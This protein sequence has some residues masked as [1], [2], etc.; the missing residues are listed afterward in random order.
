MI[1]PPRGAERM[2]DREA[3][4][5][6]L[7][8]RVDV[9]VYALGDL[10]EPYWSASAWWRRGDALLGIV[11]LPD[12]EGV[13][14]YGVSTRAPAATCALIAEAAVHLPVGQLITGPVGLGAAL[15]D[16]RP[17]RWAR[18]HQ[19]YV[20][21]DPSALI[22]VDSSAEALGPGD[23]DELAA[24]YATEPGA[25]FFLA[26]MLDG[27]VFFGIRDRGELVSVAGTHVVSI[28]HDV[29]A[30]GGVF[31]VPE[32]RE[33]G[34]ARL[35]T[36]AVASTLTTRVATIGLNVMSSNVVARNI[37]ESLGFTAV[38]AYEEAELG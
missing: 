35:L 24:V 11:Q 8:D 19:R 25:G 27:G 20:L 1:P 18:R 33:R 13:A 5:E 31:T 29:A 14:C 17:V 23:A 26:H 4:A 7:S 32:Y 21:T 3:L 36:S 34:Y 15:A 37:Y 6:F 30:V 38:F 22:G 9:H 12:G 2:A 28:R 10:D 16:V